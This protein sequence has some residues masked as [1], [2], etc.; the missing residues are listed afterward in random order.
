MSYYIHRMNGLC[1]CWRFILVLAIENFFNVESGGV[2]GGL[3]GKASLSARRKERSNN[4]IYV[5]LV[6]SNGG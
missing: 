5:G 3:E 6:Y 2:D 1:V 4:W